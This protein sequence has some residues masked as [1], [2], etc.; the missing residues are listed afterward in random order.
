[1]FYALLCRSRW[2]LGGLSLHFRWGWVALGPFAVFLDRPFGLLWPVPVLCGRPRSLRR[3]RWRR[4]SKN[5]VVYDIFGPFCV[6]QGPC[7]DQN[8]IILG[9]LDDFGSFL[10][11][12]G[13]NLQSFWH[14]FLGRSGDVFDPISGSFRAI[15]AHFWGA[16]LQKKKKKGFGKFSANLRKN[17][18]RE[19]KNMQISAKIHQIWAKL[20]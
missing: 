5:H 8:G 15:F 1:M 20:C 12:S 17:D 13:V 14:H 9:V 7:W 2:R 11:H 16:I 6:I 19:D 4:P 18:A 10:G 3:N